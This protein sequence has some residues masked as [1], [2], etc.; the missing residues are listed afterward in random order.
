MVFQVS[1]FQIEQKK[2]KVAHKHSDIKGERMDFADK[3]ERLL[4]CK[5]EQRGVKNDTEWIMQSKANNE[6]HA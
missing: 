2:G 6:A 3:M 1:K 4:S 5:S